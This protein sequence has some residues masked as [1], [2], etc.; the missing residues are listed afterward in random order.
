MKANIPQMNARD[1]FGS[2]QGFAGQFQNF[3]Q[4]PAA[5]FKGMNFPQNINPMQDPNGA[6]QYLMNSGMMSQEQ[7]NGLQQ[8]ARQIQQNPMFAQMFG[9]R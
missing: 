1:P 9:R 8:M 4:N 6:I 5:M 3:M 2:F 7:Y